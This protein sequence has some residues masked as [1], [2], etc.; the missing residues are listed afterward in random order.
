[1]LTF[2]YE[3]PTMVVNFLHHHLAWKPL[4]VYPFSYY[5]N[6]GPF[7]FPSL[8]FNTCTL[9]HNSYTHAHYTQREWKRNRVR[10]NLF[11]FIYSF[12]YL[13]PMHWRYNDSIPL[14]TSV[15]SALTR[16][17]YT[18]TK[19]IHAHN[20]IISHVFSS[21]QNIYCIL[22]WKTDDWPKILHNIF[23]LNCF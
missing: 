1:M 5:Y 3:Y 9:Q 19:N 16:Y 7:I 14:L 20:N 22:Y 4:W 13:G 11:L 15:K 10:D 21:V 18:V 8:C 17:V 2:Q 6:T 12:G 23:F